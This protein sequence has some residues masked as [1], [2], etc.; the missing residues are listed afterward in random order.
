MVPFFGGDY[1]DLLDAKIVCVSML[2]GRGQK[3][4]DGLRCDD[5]V[6]TP[7]GS[8]ANEP[9]TSAQRAFRQPNPDWRGADAGPGP[10]S[11][12]PSGQGPSH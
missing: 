11:E 8:P 2:S 9:G 5:S 3:P 10:E 1:K 4:P 12:R 7:T 6:V